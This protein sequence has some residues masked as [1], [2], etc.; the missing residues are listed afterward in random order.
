MK[1]EIVGTICMTGLAGI[2]GLMGYLYAGLFAVSAPVG[3]VL[4]AATFVGIVLEAEEEAEKNR[5]C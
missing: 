2:G 5:C 4:G 1:D 3:I